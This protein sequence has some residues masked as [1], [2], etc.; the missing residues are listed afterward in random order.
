M[1]CKRE[2]FAHANSV[3]LP[4][5]NLMLGLC[6]SVCYEIEFGSKLWINL[7]FKPLAPELSGQSTLQ[8]TWYFN[9]QPLCFMFL[10]DDL[11]RH[12]VF[13]ASHCMSTVKSSSSTQG[14]TNK[15]H[16]YY[17]FNYT[18]P[19]SRFIWMLSEYWEWNNCSFS[20]GVRRVFPC[21]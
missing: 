17:N 5:L 21:K 3:S 18:V 12:I 19:F 4:Y 13:S 1:C 7:S 11:R 20:Y 9:G 14:L 8:K 15:C 2:C 16:F 10:A 6:L